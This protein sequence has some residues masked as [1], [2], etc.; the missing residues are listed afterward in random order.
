MVNAL[1]RI[2][3]S[4]DFSVFLYFFYIC[5]NY[6]FPFCDAQIGCYFGPSLVFLPLTPQSP[7]IRI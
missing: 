4:T 6:I 3:H 1:D 5:V 2:A 7:Q